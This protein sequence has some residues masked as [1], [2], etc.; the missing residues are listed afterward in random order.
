[1]KIVYWKH[2]ET[3]VIRHSKPIPND[4]ADAAVEE[5]N[6]KYRDLYHWAEPVNGDQIIQPIEEVLKSVGFEYWPNSER[7]A[8]QKL[9]YNFAN[10]RASNHVINETERVTTTFIKILD[11]HL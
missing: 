2:K 4:S 3:G 10:K 9:M 5:M 7:R 8:L 1:M 11:R 6:V